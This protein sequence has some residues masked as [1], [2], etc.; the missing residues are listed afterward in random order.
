M[1][2]TGVNMGVF[3][4]NGV[5]T[6]FLGFISASWHDGLHVTRGAGRTTLRP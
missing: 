6:G 1:L 3:A 5:H 4:G 2:N